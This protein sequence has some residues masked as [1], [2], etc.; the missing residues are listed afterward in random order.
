MRAWPPRH[1]VV[2]ID[3]GEAS[4]RA[5]GAAATLA[6]A[7]GARVTVLHAEQFEAPPYFTHEQLDTLEAELR[8]ARTHAEAHARDFAAAHGL[9]ADMV[10]ISDRPAAEAILQAAEAADLVLLGS[11][12]RRG[13][14]RWWLGSV[15]DRVAKASPAPV[16]VVRADDPPASADELLARARP[17]DG[18]D[19]PFERGGQPVRTMIDETTFGL[20]VRPRLDFT[21]ALERTQAALKAEGFGVITTID[22]KQALEEKVGRDIRPYTILG[23]CNPQLASRALDAEAEIGLLLPCN[24]VVYEAADG[25]TV[26]AAMAPVAALGVVGENGN[27]AGVAREADAKLRRAL[28]AVAS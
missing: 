21:S 20:R 18:L 3:F 19:R 28:E 10:S 17:G 7:T 8:T 26:V 9:D 16:L 24:V 22:M 25:G 14:S 13:P 5:C 1:I 4:G 27:L 15:S 11:H 6:R 23:A 12:G 2:A